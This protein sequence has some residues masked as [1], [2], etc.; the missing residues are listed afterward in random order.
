MVRILL[1]SLVLNIRDNRLPLWNVS[2]LFL[3]LCHLVVSC[4]IVVTVR[5][6]SSSSIILSYLVGVLERKKWN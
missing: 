6:A 5:L 1:A 2:I 3:A 4:V